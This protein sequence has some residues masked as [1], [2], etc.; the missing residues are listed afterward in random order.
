MKRRA[1]STWLDRQRDRLFVLPSGAGDPRLLDLSACWSRPIWRSRASS[2]CAGGYQLHFVGLAQFRKLLFGSEQFHF[3]GVFAPVPWYGWLLLALVAWFL[4]GAV[5]CAICA[6]GG[7]RRR[8]SRPADRARPA[9][10]AILPGSVAAHARA[11]AASSA[12]SASPLL[13][14]VLGVAP[15]FVIGLGLALL[16]AQQI[17]GRGFFR[18]VFFIPLMVTPVGIAYTFRMLADMTQGPLAPIWRLLGLGD[19]AWASARLVGAHRG[20][21]RRFLAVDPLHLHR[22]A[23]G[24]R[25]PVAGP[26]RGRLP[27]RRRLLADL[28]RHDLA[29]DRA[30]RRDASC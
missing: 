10:G 6:M 22:H 20:D 21:G 23:G 7:S 17:A 15:Q 9:A 19:L 27:R 29:G 25:R 24:A 8:D 30:G 13:Y 2:S 28:S 3:L 11:R 4:S 16:C 18:V 14:V 5:W 26:D 1:S 12:R